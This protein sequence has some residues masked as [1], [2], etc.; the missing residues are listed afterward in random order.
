[1][2]VQFDPAEI[3]GWCEGQW[4]GDRPA[5]LLGASTDTRTL[6]RGCLYVALRGPSFDGHD[7]VGEAFM[8]GAAAALV[9]SEWRTEAQAGPLLR[10]ANTLM[11]LKALALEHRLKVAPRIVGVTG[12]AGKTTVKEL[13]AAVLRARWRT[14]CTCGNW[15]NEV[16]LSLS[17]LGMENTAQMGVFEVGTNHAGEIADLCGVL[18]PEWGIVTNIGAA[19]LESFA[20]VDAVAR[21][22][23]ELLRSLPADGLAVLNR[24]GG[25]YDMLAKTCAC[26]VVTV[27]GG[28]DGDY[29][30][31]VG[32][33]AK[34]GIQRCRVSGTDGQI[35]IESAL[36]GRH[37]AG[38]LAIAVALGREAGVPWEQ[39]RR[40]LGAVPHLPQRWE[41]SS[42]GGV[43]LV[44]DAY[45]AN[46]LSMNA[47]LEAFAGD[48]TVGKRWLVLAG[49]L[50]LGEAGAVAHLAVGR[51]L[52]ARCWG[53]LITVGDLGA[54]IARGA[55]EG[56]MDEDAVYTC[57]GNTEAAEILSRLAAAGDAV[58]FK[59]SRGMRLEEVKDAFCRRQ[60]EV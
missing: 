55:V 23:A 59:G 32:S 54:L 3:G 5:S 46:P 33:D 6:E 47:A 60:A 48:E 2:T 27:S 25:H 52:A 4:D 40:A 36:R 58:L 9:D 21:E 37:N 12:S 50:E 51:Q 30:W 10:V 44:N 35:E 7:F 56:G 22:K 11:A 19:H 49:M 15:N 42:S 53:G 13:T 28:A 18:R 34:G 17:L 57:G 24:D 8:R 31:T 39:V 41:V 26:R 38:N 20:S 29:R 14:A 43:K 1:M 45:N 16:G